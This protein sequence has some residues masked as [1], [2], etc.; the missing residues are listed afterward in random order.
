[1]LPRPSKETDVRHRVPAVA[2]HS[3]A[4]RVAALLS[5]LALATVAC[6]GGSDTADGSADGQVNVADDAASLD[7][8]SSD[9]DSE[10]VDDNST[11]DVG[12]LFSAE[13]VRF[14]ELDWHITDVRR[15]PDDPQDNGED[16]D[17]GEDFIHVDLEAT[18]PLPST[19]LGIPRQWVSLV[20]ADGNDVADAEGNEQ[21]VA[22]YD[23][24][25][26]PDPQRMTSSFGA[27]PGGT[28]QVTAVFSVPADYVFDGGWVKIEQPG[29]VPAALGGPTTVD[30]AARLP[31][32]IADPVFDGPMALDEARIEIIDAWVSRE[33]GTDNDGEMLNP[34]PYSNPSRRPE[35]GHAHLIVH[36]EVTCR[37]TG[38]NVGGCDL[39]AGHV[40]ADGD[41][42][43]GS[44]SGPTLAGYEGTTPMWAAYPIPL[45]TTSAVVQI[46]GAPS[47]NPDAT[48]AFEITDL[49]ALQ[50]LSTPRD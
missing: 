29:Y 13:P 30:E 3:K 28:Q 21:M 26:P 20:D 8:D 45:D 31:V 11:D 37:S 27:P 40:V 5:A 24:F 12:L 46:S 7:D 16:L 39:A 35:V 36:F 22:R 17:P 49:S 10:S 15:Q 14:F 34:S 9:D 44:L 4:A 33:I 50:S 43:P 48:T 18:N 1:V 38:I 19:G 41:P 23:S 6:G 47:M 32:G 25:E 42:L 2:R